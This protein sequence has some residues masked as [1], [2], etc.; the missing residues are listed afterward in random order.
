MAARVAATV[1]RMPPA[2]YG[3][4]AMRAANSG[5][6]SPAKTRWEWESTNP[7]MT[8]RPPA[9]TWTS[10]AGASAAG[11]TQATRSPVEDDRGVGDDAEESSSALAGSLVTSSP[12]LVMTVLVMRARACRSRRSSSRPIS[13]SSPRVKTTRPSATTWTT[14]AAVAAKTAV[15]SSRPVPA[16]RGVVVSRVTRSARLPTAM[17][18]ASSYPRLA[19]PSVV[20]ARSSSA[21]DQWPRSRVASRSSSSTARIS[22][23]RS[24]TAWLSEPRVSGLPRV[25]QAPGSGRCRRRGRARWWGRSRRRSGWRRGGRCRR[26]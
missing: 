4:P 10:A 8:A 13:C 15:C 26:R 3:V 12:M 23:N 9:S 21:A 19:W 18:P 16:V 17:A 7:G 11:P 5:A 22:S 20:A 2:A 1:V 25:V 6:R 24:M 14:S